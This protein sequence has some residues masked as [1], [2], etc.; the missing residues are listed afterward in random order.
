MSIKSNGKSQLEVSE[1]VVG[2]KP[3]GKSIELG[4]KGANLKALLSLLAALFALILTRQA[5]FAAEWSITTAPIADWNG[6]ACSA[7]GSNLVAVCFP[8][9]FNLGGIYVSTNRGATWAKTDAPDDPITNRWEA[10]ASSADGV[11]LVAVTEGGS[12]A[13]Y[14]STN[15]GLSWNQTS[16]PKRVTVVSPAHLTEPNWWRQITMVKEYILRRTQAKPGRR[17]PC[18]SSITPS[19]LVRM[20]IPFWHRHIYWVFRARRTPGCWTTL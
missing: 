10:V 14:T 19:P 5:V 2:K 11:K 15:S 8:Y 7:N 13:I 6:I 12:G 20:A 17:L 4:Q 9:I 18:G 16:A 3:K 1:M